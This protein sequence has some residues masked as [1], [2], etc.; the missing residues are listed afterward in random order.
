MRFLSPKD[1]HDDDNNKHYSEDTGTDNCDDHASTVM[2]SNFTQIYPYSGMASLLARQVHHSHV[3][4][5][6]I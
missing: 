2:L 6:N 5:G 3:V 4:P 1:D